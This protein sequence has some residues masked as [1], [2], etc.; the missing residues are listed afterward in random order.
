MQ[1]PYNNHKGGGG[2]D[3][4][5]DSQSQKDP[6]L[7]YFEKN[8][9]NLNEAN[10][11]EFVE[12]VKNY[13]ESAKFIT[14]SQI[15][16]VFHSLKEIASS[17]KENEDEQTTAVAGIQKL[18]PILAYVG[19]KNEKAEFRAFMATLENIASRVKKNK[20]VRNFYQLVESIVCYLKF[21]HPKN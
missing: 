13:C 19:G 20:D 16:N 14:T 17:L 8:T 4:N 3:R 7:E 5:R 9:L 11:N 2:Y 15:R 12:K 1:Q 6:R 10:F 18:R 21:Y